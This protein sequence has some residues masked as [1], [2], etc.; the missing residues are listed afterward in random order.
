MKKRGGKMNE[1][2]TILSLEII[3]ELKKLRMDNPI[4]YIIW[5]ILWSEHEMP[6]LIYGTPNIPLDILQ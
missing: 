3:R 6:I 1:F 2:T 5:R 4:G